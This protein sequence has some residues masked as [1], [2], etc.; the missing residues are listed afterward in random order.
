[1][2]NPLDP[3]VQSFAQDH[4][5]PLSPIKGYVYMLQ[6]GNTRRFK[7]GRSEDPERRIH[8][9][10]PG[11]PE[12]LTVY[13]KGLARNPAILERRIHAIL[14]DQRLHGEWYE[15]PWTIAEDLRALIERHDREVRTEA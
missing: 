5:D 11:N 7:I 2:P 3:L 12:I 10:Q 9:F 8:H 1:M 13:A 4:P 14:Q 15:L 6:S